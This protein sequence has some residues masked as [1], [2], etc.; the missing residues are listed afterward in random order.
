MA[1]NLAT[2]RRAVFRSWN[3]SLNDGKGDWETFTMEPDDLGQDTQMEIEFTPRK[4]SRSSSVGTTE[5]PIPGT[6]DTLT[7]TLT[8]I[9]D[10]WELLGKA[11]RNWNPASYAG[12]SS[13][14]GN[15][16]IGGA[17]DYCSGNEYLDVVLQGVCDD[18][19]ALDVELTR[20]K[21]SLDGSIS[22]GGSDATEVTL[23]LNPMIY[24]E[25]THANDGYPAYTI[26]MGSQSL[27][28][29]TRLNAATGVYQPVTNNEPATES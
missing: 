3:A 7:A 25:T 5:T 8:F 12:A 4:M 23:A 27:T 2:L 1:N 22:L 17:A 21:P 28:E 18:G 14:D 10:N 15:I 24:N 29:K 13:G 6:F 26:R 9:M 16:I 20:C 19:S 11:L